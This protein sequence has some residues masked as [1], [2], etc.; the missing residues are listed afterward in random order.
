ML[1]KLPSGLCID[2][3]IVKIIFV[4]REPVK[5]GQ[6]E[7]V[8]A[9]YVRTDGELELRLGTPET[10]EEAINLARLAADM[11]NRGLK[12]EDEEDSSDDDDDDDDDTDDDTDE[13]AQK[14]DSK[15]ADS[16]DKPNDSTSDQDDEDEEE[17]APEEEFDAL[18]ALDDL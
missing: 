3:E 4:K 1:V 8:W 14:D 12:G 2:P 7:L 13:D 6:K 17:E 10:E 18:S 5:L 16:E 9:V 15:D 11:I